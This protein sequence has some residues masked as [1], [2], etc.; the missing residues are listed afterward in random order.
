MKK[1]YD[2]IAKIKNKSNKFFIEKKKKKV[3]NFLFKWIK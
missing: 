1:I 2:H 3:F